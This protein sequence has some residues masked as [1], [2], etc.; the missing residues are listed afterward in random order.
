MAVLWHHRHENLLFDH[1]GTRPT[2]APPPVA[3]LGA[4]PIT[5]DEVLRRFLVWKEQPAVNDSSLGRHLD[6]LAASYAEAAL[7]GA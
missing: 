2:A 6:D 5:S 4:G 1:D 7:A 3:L